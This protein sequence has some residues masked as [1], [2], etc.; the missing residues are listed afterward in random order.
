MCGAVCL[1]CCSESLQKHPGRP[2]G[3]PGFQGVFL[4]ELRKFI[5][6]PSRLWLGSAALSF[7]GYHRRAFQKSEEQASLF[8]DAC[9]MLR[10]QHSVDG[11]YPR[12]ADQLIARHRNVTIWALVQFAF[13]LNVVSL[14][15]LVTFSLTAH[16]TALE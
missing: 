4:F 15:P 16:R 9:S 14:V 11:G 7:D 5:R 8:I 1:S 13:G 6:F 2:V 3:M 12:P 10:T